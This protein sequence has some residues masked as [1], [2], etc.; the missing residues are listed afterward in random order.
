MMVTIALL[1]L[2]HRHSGEARR[3]PQV[4]A[5]LHQ[6]GRARVPQNVRVGFETA[7]VIAFL[8]ALQ[9]NAGPRTTLRGAP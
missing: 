7:R 3:G 9:A 6:P 5:L 2:P 8:F 1:E 4:D